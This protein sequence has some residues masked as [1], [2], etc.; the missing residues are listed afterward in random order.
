MSMKNSK[1]HASLKVEI[2][3]QV[4]FNKATEITRQRKRKKGKDQDGNNDLEGTSDK[5]K[6]RFCNCVMV[7]RKHKSFQPA[8]WPGSLAT[9]KW[10]F[11]KPLRNYEIVAFSS[12]LLLFSY[13]T[14]AYLFIIMK[15]TRTR[16]EM[17]IGTA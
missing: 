10:I 5:R 8:P 1:S 12:C 16:A 3:I 6:K 17:S 9:G 14:V 13:V 15:E 4:I 2:S 7:Y 11:S